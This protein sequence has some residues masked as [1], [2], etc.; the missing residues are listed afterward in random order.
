MVDDFMVC[1]DRLISPSDCL[2]NGG[3]GKNVEAVAAAATTSGLNENG[4]GPVKGFGDGGEGCSS[5]KE[6]ED[7]VECRIC[8]EEDEEHEME[9]PCACNGT[10]KFAHRKCIQRWCN[11]KGNTTCEICKQVF[12]PNYSVPPVRANPDIMAIDIRQALGQ[13][14]DLR[15]PHLLALAAAEHRFLRSEY[16][17]YASA[18]TGSIVCFRSVVAQICAQVLLILLVRL[19]LMITRDS[20]VEQEYPTFFN[21]KFRF[22]FFNLLGSFC[23]A[24]SWLDQCTL[25]TSEGEDMADS[26]WIDSMSRISS[27]RWRFT[28]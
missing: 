20:G 26:V 1:V 3:V 13:Q 24:I 12:S 5:V 28:L 17:D 15:N 9:A 4:D 7:M 23:H 8:Q 11:K 19:A 21:V 10:L 22:R 25:F 14:I 16:E 18:N 27:K 6:V 2:V